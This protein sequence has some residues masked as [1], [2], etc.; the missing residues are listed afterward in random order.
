MTTKPEML[1]AGALL[2]RLRRVDKPAY[3]KVTPTNTFTSNATYINPDGPKAANHIEALSTQLAE[4]EAE[5]VRLR[6]A[7]ERKDA[8]L[9]RI[10]P[11]ID[12]IV[13]YASTMGEHEP[14][15]L[16]VDLRALTIKDNSNEG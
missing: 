11:H 5:L 2:E 13:C 16:A 10:E 8:L 14:N 6:E 12:A 15:R 7:G 3:R 4:R 1:D 9:R